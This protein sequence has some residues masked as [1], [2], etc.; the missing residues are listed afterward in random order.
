[1]WVGFGIAMLVI[2]GMF[3]SMISSPP[4]IRDE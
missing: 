4:K 3:F 1:M 2:L